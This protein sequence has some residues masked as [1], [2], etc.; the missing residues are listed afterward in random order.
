ILFPGDLWFCRG[1]ASHHNC[2]RATLR[3]GRRAMSGSPAALQPWLPG[4]GC[5]RTTS[6]LRRDA[7]ARPPCW[8]RRAGIRR[9]T[10]K[11]IAASC[12]WVDAAHRPAPA[13]VRFGSVRELLH[14]ELPVP[15]C[16]LPPCR[17]WLRAGPLGPARRGAIHRESEG[18]ST[19]GVGA[20]I[21]HPVPG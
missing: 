10:S 2:R 6:P 7:A 3:V 16:P 9:A 14:V 8:N 17:K 20:A 1:R 13:V 18:A 11:E 5:R 19:V 15:P 12:F 4:M 21:A